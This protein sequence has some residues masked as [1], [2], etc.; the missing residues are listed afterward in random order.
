MREQGPG[1]PRS[2][3]RRPMSALLLFILLLC[4]VLAG[5]T[6]AA[7]GAVLQP[8]DCIECHG[9]DV[10]DNHH[11]TIYFT[12][13]QC[14]FCHTGVI[15]TGECDRCHTFVPRQNAHHATDPALQG[16]C[17]LCHTAVGD[18]TDCSSCHPGTDIRMPHHDVASTQNIDCV[19]CHTT[20]QAGDACQ[21]CHGVDTRAT[22]HAAIEPK[23]LACTSCHSGIIEPSDCT[24]CH[25]PGSWG[26]G[27]TAASTHHALASSTNR[28]CSD[29]HSGVTPIGG[30]GDCHSFSLSNRHHDS[31]LGTTY[32]VLCSS[33]HR[34]VW[35]G[36]TNRYL[37]PTPADCEAC[38]TGATGSVFPPGTIPQIHHAA[39]SDCARCHQGIDTIP[40]GLDCATC[41]ATQA[42]T[43]DVAMHHATQTYQDNLCAICH[44]GVGAGGLDCSACHNGVIA[45]PGTVDTHHATQKYLDGQ[46]TECHLG[47][48]IEGIVCAACHD[49]G[50]SNPRDHHGRAD[51]L[52]DNCVACHS[53][54]QLNG[55][56]CQECHSGDIPALHHGGPLAEVGGDCTFCHQ[57]ASDPS[58]CANCHEASP[59][60]TTSWSLDGDC[61]HCHYVPAFAQDRPMQAACRECHGPYQH[62]KN[63]QPIQDY[64]ACAACH[65]Q[66]PFHAAPARAVGYTKPA[67][68]KGIFAL[69]WAQFTDNGQDQE[70]TFLENI[71]PNGEDMDDEGGRRWRN[72]SLNF[73]MR[74]ISHN[75][76]TYSV[77]AFPDLPG[78]SRDT[79]S[80]GGGTPPPPAAAVNL[81]LNQPATASGYEGASYTP[82]KAVDGSTSTAWWRNSSRSQWLRVDL[83]QR[84]SI[85]RVVVTW[86][87]EYA[88]QYDVEVSNDGYSWSRVLQE[89]AGN[90][91]TDTIGFSSREARYVR[92][93]CRSEYRNGYQ[94]SELE[95]YK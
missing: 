90:G 2:R 18:L 49:P 75:G 45:P 20:I 48:G 84:Q 77:P 31:D 60:H 92:V 12:T 37:P 56:G 83:G 28:D 7:L 61:A 16:N 24:D 87:Q 8:S 14:T 40:G 11:K 44:V 51:Y 34:T 82:S 30:C 74:Q 29:C 10:A 67:P 64:G 85:A 62:G 73:N 94:I 38:H 52:A 27:Q 68:G 70:G 63:T 88:R 65:N 22:H 32:G 43:G 93:Y 1:G 58:V 54:I 13:G 47:T 91:G 19:S 57:S 21:D 26:P 81:A 15:T 3:Q 4:A 55:N 69:F 89:G 59:H 6:T 33:C 36:Y 17:A 42:K 50:T 72:P 78:T 86:G 79:S 71:S 95:V 39:S 76:R 80:G 23:N 25:T 9:A 5:G 46:C 53:T 66:A 35:N 41:H